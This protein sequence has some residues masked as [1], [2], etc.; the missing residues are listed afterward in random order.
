M[1]RRIFRFFNSFF[2]F[3]SFIIKITVRVISQEMAAAKRGLLS[4]VIDRAPG[5][6]SDPRIYYGSATLEL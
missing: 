5:T 3:T 6:K 2:L 4:G 1:Y